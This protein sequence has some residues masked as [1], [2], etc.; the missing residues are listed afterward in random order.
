M[1]VIL[2]KPGPGRPHLWATRPQV[3]AKGPP[4]ANA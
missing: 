2:L 3:V 4:A 1:P